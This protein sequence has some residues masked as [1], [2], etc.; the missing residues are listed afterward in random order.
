MR[1]TVTIDD[2]LYETALELADPSMDKADI[3]REAMKMFVRVQAGKRLAA[4]GGAAPDMQDVPRR[5][6]EVEA[7]G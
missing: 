5:R 2:V 6:S 3:F 4:L 7:Q 1:T